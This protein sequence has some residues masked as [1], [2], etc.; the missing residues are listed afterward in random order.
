MVVLDVKSIM[1]IDNWIEE[2]AIAGL[3]GRSRLV[4]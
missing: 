1:V 4:I 3:S 2:D